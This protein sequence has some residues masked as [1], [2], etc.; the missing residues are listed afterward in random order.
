MKIELG[1]VGSWRA[2][3]LGILAMA[4]VISVSNFL[5]QYPIND[6]LTWGH[7]SFPVTFFVA[8]L[9]N[10]RLGASRARTV[11]YV[12]FILAVVVSYWLA[13]PRIAV[14]SGSAFII[15]QLINIGVFDRLR[16]RNWWHAPFIS[17][18][19]ASTVDTIVFYGIA[20]A[21]T[22]LPWVTW[23]IG[24]YAVKLASAL[25]LILP[26]FIV[27]RQFWSSDEEDLNEKTL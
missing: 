3:L 15:G 17:S 2:V 23:S 27:T 19:I 9:V 8:D 12:G 4:L 7:F 14:A 5:V 10:R 1:Q 21:G 20:F 26:Y 24:D 6:W 25:F 18:S 22:G 16:D 13:S 11:A